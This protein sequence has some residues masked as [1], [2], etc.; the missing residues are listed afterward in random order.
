M[1]SLKHIRSQFPKNPVFSSLFNDDDTTTVDAQRHLHA[2]IKELN[3]KVS[4][5]ENDTETDDISRTLHNIDLN[6]FGGQKVNIVGRPSMPFGKAAGT[7]SKTTIPRF[8]VTTPHQGPEPVYSEISENSDGYEELRFQE[9]D[10]SEGYEVPMTGN[11][12]TS[13]LPTLPKKRKTGMRS[14][15]LPVEPE[16]ITVTAGG[17]PRLILKKHIGGVGEEVSKQGSK[18]LATKKRFTQKNWF[19]KQQTS[20]LQKQPRS[21]EQSGLETT[22]AG[23]DLKLIIDKLKRIKPKSMQIDN[24]SAQFISSQSG[25]VSVGN[26]MDKVDF[27]KDTGPIGEQYKYAM[28]KDGYNF[29]QCLALVLFDQLKEMIDIQIEEEEHIVGEQVTNDKFGRVVIH[30]TKESIGA[31]YSPDDF[32]KMLPELNIMNLLN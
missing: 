21:Q 2:K 31:P 15:Q 27:P 25:S 9:D 30:T 6:D 24:Q 29:I 26:K 11:M 17:G 7:V 13:I 4:I 18:D 28:E 12:D 8:A 20:A 19:N 22:D 1:A 14:A 16:Y 32:M 3:L 10:S 23:I 5:A